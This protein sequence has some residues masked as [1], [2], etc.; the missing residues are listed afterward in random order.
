MT[1]YSKKWLWNKL[2]NQKEARLITEELQIIFQRIITSRLRLNFLNNSILVR[3]G[4]YDILH[5]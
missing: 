4:P 5:Q 3:V 1:T 2:K